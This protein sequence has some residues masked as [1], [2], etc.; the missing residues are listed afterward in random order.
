MGGG[1]D[2]AYPKSCTRWSTLPER[3]SSL[4]GCQTPL[5]NAED[6]CRSGWLQI[7]TAT[8][9][10]SLPFDTDGAAVKDEASPGGNQKFAASG[11][12]A[13]INRNHIHAGDGSENG[14]ASLPVACSR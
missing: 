8:G 12:Q 7:G 4:H 9:F 13:A 3:R 2:L 10:I 6:P 5:G 14:G 11:D 1:Y